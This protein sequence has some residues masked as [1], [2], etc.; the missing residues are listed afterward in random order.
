MARFIRSSRGSSLVLAALAVC[1]GAGATVA[2]AGENLE[3]YFVDC[4]GSVGNATLLVSPSG[5]S[6]MLDSG[7]P[8]VAK[9][10]VRV[11][12]QAGLSS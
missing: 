12:K 1:F 2:R 6:M 10:V 11:I 7:P 5:E 4:G 9:R 8:Y 3:I